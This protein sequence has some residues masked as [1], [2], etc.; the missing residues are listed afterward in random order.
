MQALQSATPNA[1]FLVTGTCR[2]SVTVMTDD[3][4]IDGQ[5]QTIFVR[6]H[7]TVRAI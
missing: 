5:H 2:E 6:Q 7:G 1:T 4:V 3:I